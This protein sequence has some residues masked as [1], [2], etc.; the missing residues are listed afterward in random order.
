VWNP[1]Q[2]KLSRCERGIVVGKKIEVILLD[3]VVGLGKIGARVNV[4]KGYAR[5][6]LFP[7]EKAQRATSDNIAVL[8]ERLSKLRV[9]QEKILAQAQADAAKIEK[10]PLTILERAGDEGKLFGSVTVVDILKL[11]KEHYDMP[12]KKHHIKLPEGTRTLQNI[13]EYEID[14]LLHDEVQAKFQLVIQKAADP[15]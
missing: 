5:N 11:I 6:F 14:V 9:E 12:L 3:N 13:G 2:V 8:E 1:C 4:A 15:D 7:H 10:K